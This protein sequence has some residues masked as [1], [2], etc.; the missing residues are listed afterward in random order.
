[1]PLNICQG[2]LIAQRVDAIVNT[3]NVVGVMGKGI[4]LQFKRKWPDN[5]KQYLAA[6]KRNEVRIGEMFVV[7]NGKLVQ[8]HFIINFPTKKHWRNPSKMEYIEDGLIDLVDKIRELGISSIALPPLGCG[9]GGLDWEEVRPKIEAA[10][11]NVPWVDVR[12]FPPSGGALRELVPESTPTR[13]TAGRAAMVA[14]LSMYQ[15][16]NYALTMI[17]T[18]KLAYFLDYSGERLNMNFKKHHFGPYAL[19]LKH[20]LLK[21]DGSYISGVGDLTKPSEIQVL[22][23]ALSEAQAFLSEQNSHETLERVERL[24][25]LIEGFETP[26]GMELLATAHWAAVNTDGSLDE[27]LAY[28]HK[29]SDRKKSIMSERLVAQAYDRLVGEGWLAS[30]SEPA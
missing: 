10:F 29:W 21:M 20:V 13:M 22:P 6:C 15:R 19:E 18:Q 8:P 23:K 2:D 16:L 1:M 25:R 5:Y 3:V 26:F 4:A 14:V 27:V 11:S 9:N 7:D 28:V 12:L 17:E 30:P 24:S